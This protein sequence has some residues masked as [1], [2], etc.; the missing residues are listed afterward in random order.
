MVHGRIVVCI[1]E[2]MVFVVHL[3]VLNAHIV[4]DL[5]KVRHRS[6]PALC[7]QPMVHLVA[8][9]EVARKHMATVDRHLAVVEIE[10]FW[11]NVGRETALM[12]L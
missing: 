3:A 7:I 11:L 5:V 2:E 8:P 1:Y 9:V 12:R 6:A 10:H 4:R